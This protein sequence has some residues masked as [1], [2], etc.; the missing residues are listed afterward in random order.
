VRRGDAAPAACA[1]AGTRR[2][3]HL[4][5]VCSRPDPRLP[6]HDTKWRAEEAVRASGLDFTILKPPSS[7]TG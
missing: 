5:V 6:Y 1:E 4:S 7:T 3:I 2:F